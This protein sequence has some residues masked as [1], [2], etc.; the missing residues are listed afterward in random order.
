M[1]ND[2]RERKG[3]EYDDNFRPS[4]SVDDLEAAY[5]SASASD[6]DMPNGHPSKKSLD[7]DDLKGA[8]AGAKNNTTSA[9]A[10][11]GEQD[12]LGKGFTG[13]DALGA[14]L[15]STPT[16]R[17]AKFMTAAKSNKGKGAGIGGIIFS[18]MLAF[19]GLSSFNLQHYSDNFLKKT[20]GTANS[21]LKKRKLKAFNN[22]MQRVSRGSGTAFESLNGANS[23]KALEADGLKPNFAKGQLEFTS[24]TGETGILDLKAADF[25]SEVKSFLQKSDSFAA[26]FSEKV[27]SSEKS[28]GQAFG[29]QTAESF[30]S[31]FKITRFIKWL[32]RAEPEGVSAA[33]ALADAVKHQNDALRAQDTAIAEPGVNTLPDEQAKDPLA[34]KQNDFLNAETANIADDLVANADA[35]E[36]ASLIEGDVAAAASAEFAE[37]IEKGAML[38]I[39]AK[40]GL[41]VASKAAPLIAE[42]A[43]TFGLPALQES[44]KIKGKL[45]MVNNVRRTMYAI[46]LMGI[47]YDFLTI[48]SHQRAGLVTGK[49]LAK[50]QYWMGREDKNT[51]KSFSNSGGINNALGNKNTHANPQNLGKLSVGFASAGILASISRFVNR[52]PGVSNGCKFANNGFVNLGIAIVGIGAAI[53]CTA[54]SVGSAIANAAPLIAL[55]VVGEVV[56]QIATPILI[57]SGAK[58]A[59]NGL[60]SG[61]F[62][63]DAV[64]SGVGTA[65]SSMNGAHALMPTTVPQYTALKMI[66]DE[67]NK[68]E[69]AKMS[70]F[71][72][73]FNRDNTDSLLSKVAVK[74]LPYSDGKNLGQNIAM[75]GLQTPRTLAGSV[76]NMFVPPSTV[77][78]E[79]T[80]SLCEDPQFVDNNIATDDFCNPVVALSPQID[81]TVAQTKLLANGLIDSQGLPLGKFKSHIKQCLSGTPG[82]MYQFDVPEDG[83]GNGKTNEC[84]PGNG[85]V[86]SGETNKLADAYGIETPT[87]NVAWWRKLM[88]QKAYAATLPIYTGYVTDTDYMTAWY[89]YLDD[90]RDISADLNGSAASAD[91]TKLPVGGFQTGF[92][93]A[94]IDTSKMTCPSS[95]TITAGS[96]VKVFD[97]TAGFYNV[98]L[99][100]V[101]GYSINAIKAK[102]FDDMYNSMITAGYKP[103]TVDSAGNYSRDGGGG[104]FRT[105]DAQA[106]GYAKNPSAFAPPGSSNHEKG[107][108]V[109]TACANNDGSQLY[110]PWMTGKDRG[111]TAFTKAINEHPCLDWI[112]NNSAR[113][114]LLLQCDGKGSGG[115]QIA[116]DRGGC[117]TWHLSPTGG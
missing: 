15:S 59:L 44:C 27:M 104:N 101:R 93:V 71:D 55:V 48:A 50:Y 24:S 5:G 53:A 112:H 83:S 57:K 51:G 69:L 109:D 6:G 80:G 12:R 37:A 74:L 91:S 21:V 19:F 4:G 34:V 16:G 79:G 75:L 60:E 52:L 36:A 9:P 33:K 41:D 107:L 42:S 84:L 110:Y 67:Q 7:G 106:A 10:L 72:R 64:S 30:Y 94:S 116:A 115:G 117:E 49:A 2:L 102:D 18:L 56:V 38:D 8:E 61:E 63:G 90:A 111:L 31:R 35:V 68:K 17:V 70:I 85:V 82:L 47:G 46:Q 96:V 78:A 73:Y 100:N 43:L 108:A 66:S 88:G 81:P 40:S 58:M 23:L 26:E 103:V 77:Y 114:R 1:P 87:Q 54:C 95:P 29:G 86:F 97:T 65:M 45:Q 113:F 28:L 3:Y 11:G 76:G 32:S 14:V 22:V 39:A 98:K 62:L 13:K 105:Y 25:D 20:N 99:C 89:A 92:P